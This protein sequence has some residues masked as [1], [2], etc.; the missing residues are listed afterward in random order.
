[1]AVL[2][3]RMPRWTRSSIAPDWSQLTSS[4]TLSVMFKFR[5]VCVRY[6]LFD[7][8]LFLSE[9]KKYKYLVSTIVYIIIKGLVRQSWWVAEHDAAGEPT[10]WR[11]DGAFRVRGPVEVV[12]VTSTWQ[13]GGETKWKHDDYFWWEMLWRSRDVIG[14]SISNPRPFDVQTSG[15]PMWLFY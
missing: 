7:L 3:P 10:L 8:Y 14:P 15:K 5:C 6:S 1:M 4:W 11:K 13:V 2:P 12:M 9:R